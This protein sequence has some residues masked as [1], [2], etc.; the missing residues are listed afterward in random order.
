VKAYLKLRPASE[1]A[2]L[3]TQ[4][5]SRPCCC[6]RSTFPTAAQ[7]STSL[8]EFDDH[9]MPRN[10]AKLKFT[11]PTNSLPIL[12]LFNFALTTNNQVINY[13]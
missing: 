10:Q 1:S 3:A 11:T 12:D 7:Q 5:H 13:H 2:V 8:V 6:P 9:V 4:N